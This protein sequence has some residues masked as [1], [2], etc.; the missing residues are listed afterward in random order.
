MA[1]AAKGTAIRA[2]QYLRMSSDNQ[3]Y[4]TENQQNAIAEYAASHGYEVVS[5][6]IDAGKSGLSLK[7]RDALRQLLSDAL[8]PQRAFDAILVLDVSRWGR[9][10]N[11]DQ[12]AHYEYLCRE[13]G[14][15]VVYCGEPFGDDVAP[16]TTIVKHLKRIMAGEYSRELSA[17]LSRAHLQQAQLGFRQGGKLIYG[18]RRMLVDP[19]RIP[20]QMLNDGDRKALSCDKVIVIPGPPEELVVIRRI[21]R[22]YVRE[23]LS[24]PEITSRLREAGVTGYGDK[25]LELHTIRHILSN[26]LCIGRMTYNVTS[27]KLQGRTINNPK[28]LWTRFQAFDPIISITLFQRAQD[29]LA[30]SAK[31]RWDKDSILQSLSQLLSEVGSLTQAI[32]NRSY[33]APSATTVAECFGSLGAAY[34]AIGYKPTTTPP[35]GNN[36]KSWSKK[37]VLKG[38]KKLYES[39]GRVS[40]RL[41]DSCSVLPSQ[42]HIRRHFGSIPNALKEAG[43]PVLSHGEIQRRSWKRR[44]AGGCSEYFYG[45]YWPDKNLLRALRRLHREYGYISRSLLDQNTTTPSGH[46]FVKRFGSLNDARAAAKLP[47][48]THSQV[49]ADGCKRRKNGMLIPRKR[50]TPRYPE[51]RP[52]LR[53]RS[54]EILTRLKQL[55]LREGH[56]SSRLIDEDSNLPSFATVAKHFGSLSAA[57]KLAG[58]VRLPGKPVRFGPAT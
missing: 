13:A 42:A 1:D 28:H 35:F 36:G 15:K 17:K 29:R 23:N 52:S 49:A 32:I 2:A 22:L 40:T 56:V 14:V 57:Y 26:E 48:P 4:S 43:L 39:E 24:L 34:E 3:R 33:D 12:A 50:A 27:K 41:I 46:Y 58:L 25:P 20:K 38:L 5:S 37:A 45:V 11:P 31:R 6:Y 47:V 19:S 44:K 51:Q 7:G 54:S 21:F 18:F 10:Q 8:A 53:Y 55:A 30:R 9:F 16:I